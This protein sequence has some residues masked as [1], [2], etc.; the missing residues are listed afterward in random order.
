MK[1]TKVSLAAL[2]ALG[3]FS[4]V[5]S[6]TPL[7]EAIK[8]VDLSGFARYR[9]TNDFIKN[10]NQNSTVKNSGAGHAFRMQTAFK[11]AID[12]NF[13]GVLNLRY[14]L[15][16]DS[17]DKNAAGTDKTYTTG[18]FGVYE[19]YLGYKA[20]NTTITAGKQL[21]GTFFDDKDVAGTGLKVINTDVPGLTLAAAAFDAVQSDGT[22]LDGPLLKTL[23]GSI[24]DAPGNIYYLG[25]A[26]SYDPVS[27]KAAI[28]N[29]QEVATLYGAD[30]GVSFNVTDDVNLNLKGQFVHNDSDHKDVADANFWAVQAGTKLFGAKLNAGYLDFDAKNKDN[31]KISFAT[32]DA[33]GELINPAKILNGVMSGGRQ[34][35]NNIK[36]NNDYWFVKA[37][38]DIDKFGFG[39]GYVQGK[40]TSYALQ[41]LRAKRSEWSLDAS[42]KYSKKLTFLSWYAAAKDKKDGASYKQDRIRFEAKYSF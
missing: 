31:N 4:S 3:A 11:A 7:E 17:G 23:T 20:G 30:A 34:Y 42:Y 29:V 16:D 19:M 33:N 22:E 32:L 15:T 35:Y 1:L 21:L 2:V 37:G 18:T 38:Y 36:G 24:S 40:G 14:D 12:D 41:E 25:A 10:S 27:F 6:A 9:Y 39:A 5:A 8:N 28:A 26:G 13:F